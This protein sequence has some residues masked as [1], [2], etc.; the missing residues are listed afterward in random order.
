MLNTIFSE[1]ILQS[2]SKHVDLALGFLKR[3]TI[4][5]TVLL[6]FLCLDKTVTGS[7]NA[8]APRMSLYPLTPEGER[9]VCRQ[10]R[11]LLRKHPCS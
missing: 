2:L 1:A 5:A 10:L 9:L 3:V 6:A 7:Q 8:S 4:V 11:G